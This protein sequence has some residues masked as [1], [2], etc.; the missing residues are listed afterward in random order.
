MKT[1]VCSRCRCS[2]PVR[3][4][5]R[6]GTSKTGRQNYTPKCKECFSESRRDLEAE[7]RR[8]SAEAKAA[9]DI[10]VNALLAG[11]SSE[12]NEKYISYKSSRQKYI[13]QMDG[14]YHGHFYTIEG[15]RAKKAELLEKREANKRKQRIEK[16]E[17]QL[18]SIK[19]ELE[20]LKREEPN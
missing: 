10:K 7:N 14:K 8:S 16:L 18:L 5:Y 13:V 4:F 2:K 15:A 12:F 11:N 6:N 1:K 19:N 3:D 9:A 17:K 20:D